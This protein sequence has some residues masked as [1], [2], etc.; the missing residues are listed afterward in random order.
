M[1]SLTPKKKYIAEPTIL[2]WQSVLFLFF[3]VPVTLANDPFASA[4]STDDP[5]MKELC[6]GLDTTVDQKAE[7]DVRKTSTP[8]A[9]AANPAGVPDVEVSSQKD[10]GEIAKATMTTGVDNTGQEVAVNSRKQEI[11]EDGQYR[12]LAAI[13]E[14]RR[15]REAR[16]TPYS[17]ADIVR[18]N[19]A[20]DDVKND[21]IFPWNVAK[22]AEDERLREHLKY[23]SVTTQ[24]ERDYKKERANLLATIAQ[25]SQMAM[26]TQQRATN[27]GTATD[28]SGDLAKS[29]SAISPKSPLAAKSTK[30]GEKGSDVSQ[31]TADPSLADGT[32][33]NDLSPEDRK[34]LQTAIDAAKKR[35]ELLALKKKLKNQLKGR[36]DQKSAE[37][38][39]ATKS[40]S[41]DLIPD[42]PERGL[43]STD[44]EKEKEDF[45]NSAVFH[46]MQAQ[47]SMDAGHTRAEVE[48]ML[49][50]VEKE[51]GS[52]GDILAGILESNSRSL[53]ERV[54]EAHQQCLKAECVLGWKR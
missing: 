34:K 5:E 25:L 45:L 24:L 54:R 23:I 6:M 32:N 33:P 49:D 3:M 13:E 43:A 11:L 8:P 53:F 47:F 14:D 37:A 7:A 4:C 17:S 12:A 30:L 15:A 19:R 27:M 42:E 52:T 21:K 18:A 35:K 51:L 10:A 22:T 48:R 26:T 41:G 1:K 39:E 28:P 40:F 50:E 29:A 20:K 16:G 38:D 9:V 2:V 44:P 31:E 46:A 36:A